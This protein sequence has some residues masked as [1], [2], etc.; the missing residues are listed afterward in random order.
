[1]SK[2][3][4]FIREGEFLTLHA[5]TLN[6]TKQGALFQGGD[7]QTYR[8]LHRTEERRQRQQQYTHHRAHTDNICDKCGRMYRGK[9]SK[10]RHQRSQ[11]C[12]KLAEQRIQP[13]IHIDGDNNNV[14]INIT[15]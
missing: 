12:Q 6:D 7:M 5:A 13:V 1:M 10:L 14:T 15:V 9:Y 8:Q 11:K 2:R 3:Q 4:R